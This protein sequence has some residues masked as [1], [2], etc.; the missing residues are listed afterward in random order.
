[1]SWITDEILEDF[2]NFMVIRRYV[3]DGLL[4]SEVRRE[5][6]VLVLK[7]QLSGAEFTISSLKEWKSAKKKA[8]YKEGDKGVMRSYGGF[9]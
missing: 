9:W 3:Y 1:M 2:D 6:G 7:D 5:E 4:G 8:K